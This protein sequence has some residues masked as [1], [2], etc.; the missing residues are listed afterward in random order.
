MMTKDYEKSQITNKVQEVTEGT[1]K[2]YEGPS[3]MTKTTQDY[4]SP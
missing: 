2:D 1:K 3:K 4:E